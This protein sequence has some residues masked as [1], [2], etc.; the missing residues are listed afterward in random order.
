MITSTGLNDRPKDKLLQTV[1]CTYR[2]INRTSHYSPNI[3][4][5]IKSDSPC[6]DKLIS[7]DYW[8]HSRL[9]KQNK[10]YRFMLC[11]VFY[12]NQTITQYLIFVLTDK[13][14]ARCGFPYYQIW[15]HSLVWL[16]DR[17][18][19]LHEPHQRRDHLCY[20]STWGHLRHHRCQQEGTGKNVSQ[21]LN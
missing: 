10:L 7:T 11:G 20:C 14:Q 16:G 21:C 3:Y 4:F 18:L 6:S 2:Q 5:K 12:H 13:L 17:H 8:F 19:H 9:M 15:L 1:C